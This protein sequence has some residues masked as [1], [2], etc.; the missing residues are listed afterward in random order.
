MSTNKRKA[1]IEELNNKEVEFRKNAIVNLYE[2]ADILVRKDIEER[3]QLSELKKA[4]LNPGSGSF[5]LSSRSKSAP[6]K[7][8][9]KSRRSKSA[10]QSRKGGKK[11]KKR[12]S[13]K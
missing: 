6:I 5:S 7:S 10:S 8:R 9:S 1:V 13:T 11:T 12:R 3:N 4:L 2:L